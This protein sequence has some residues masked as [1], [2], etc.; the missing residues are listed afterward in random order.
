MDLHPWSSVILIHGSICAQMPI[1]YNNLIIW[2]NDFKC[3]K[4]RYVC[5]GHKLTEEIELDV[6]KI[7]LANTFVY[8]G[9]NPKRDS[10]STVLTNTDFKLIKLL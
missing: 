9:K 3:I 2:P 5:I 6:L 10:F 1:G 7:I 8:I 4:N